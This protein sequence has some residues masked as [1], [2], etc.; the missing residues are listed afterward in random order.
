MPPIFVRFL[1]G[2]HGADVL[3]VAPGRIG[4]LLTAPLRLVTHI[5][6]DLNHDSQAIARVHERF[7][8]ALI[9]GI[10]FVERQGKPVPFSIPAELLQTWGVNWQP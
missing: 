8:R 2:D 9:Q 5:A 6:S 10:L 4:E 7:A 1:L 3:G